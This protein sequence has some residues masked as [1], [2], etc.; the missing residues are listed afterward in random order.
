MSRHPTETQMGA[1]MI[2]VDASGPLVQVYRY[3]TDIVGIGDVEQQVI[4]TIAY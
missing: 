1:E 2:P 4:A 3:D